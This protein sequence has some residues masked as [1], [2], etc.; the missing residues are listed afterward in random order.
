MVGNHTL[1]V[2]KP[3]GVERRLIGRIISRFE[4]AGL[5]V[6][7]MHMLTPTREL[8]EQHYPSTEGWFAD[9]GGKTLGDY[10]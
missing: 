6:V 5:R 7:K 4:E 9:V 3:D 2:V 10:A 1:V 8:I